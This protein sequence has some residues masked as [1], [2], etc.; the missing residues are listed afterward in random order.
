MT[1]DMTVFPIVRDVFAGP[2]TGG[3]SG[4]R[5]VLDGP[6]GEGR[7]LVQR[8]LRCGVVRFPIAPACH[9]CLAFEFDWEPLAKSGTVHVAVLVSRA[10]GRWDG[11]VP[12]T[13]GL[14][15]M[16]H[17]IRL[18]GRIFC[19]CGAGSSP[20][21]PVDLRGVPDADGGHVFAFT[22]DCWQV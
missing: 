3:S 15:N 18:P 21:A 10:A 7:F 12:F 22:H 1:Q 17:G 16:D 5:A 2:G 13:A 11:G 9:A 4:E 6:G 8:C 14:V 20:G 19:R